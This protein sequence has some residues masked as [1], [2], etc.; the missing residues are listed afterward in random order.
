MSAEEQRA[1]ELMELAQRVVMALAKDGVNP[2][3]G[4]RVSILVAAECEGSPMPL[5]VVASFPKRDSGDIVADLA[6]A[7]LTMISK[8]AIMH[9]VDASNVCTCSKC[10]SR[11]ENTSAK[12]H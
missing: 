9:E 2:G 6:S 11:R 4:M 5:F 8:P 12:A 3:P 7:A 10:T 1:V